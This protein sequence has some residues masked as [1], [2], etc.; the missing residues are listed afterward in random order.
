M[1]VLKSVKALSMRLKHT[2]HMLGYTWGYVA[3][4]PSPAEPLDKA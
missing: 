3:D 1:N 2:V 4:S